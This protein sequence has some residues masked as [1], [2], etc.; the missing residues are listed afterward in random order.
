MLRGL[1]FSPT[2]AQGVFVLYVAPR[3]AA[4]VLLG[5]AFLGATP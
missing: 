2:G 1:L 4:S 3:K 5:G